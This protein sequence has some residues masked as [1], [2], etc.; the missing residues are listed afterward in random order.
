MELK[1]KGLPPSISD[2]HGYVV[3][4]REGSA[5]LVDPTTQKWWTFATI[6]SARWNA[7]VMRRLANT[8]KEADQAPE[9]ASAV[10]LASAFRTATAQISVH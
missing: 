7:A 3:I 4:E 5:D 1:I 10:L 9:G 2:C 8:A 6:R